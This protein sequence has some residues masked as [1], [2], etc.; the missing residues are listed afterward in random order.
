M[1]FGQSIEYNKRRCFFKNHA[2]NEAERLHL[3]NLPQQSTNIED[4][5]QGISLFFSICHGK[6]NAEAIKFLGILKKKVSKNKKYIFVYKRN[7]SLNKKVIFVFHTIFKLD[8]TMQIIYW[9][10]FTCFCCSLISVSRKR[11]IETMLTPL[12][13]YDWQKFNNMNNKRS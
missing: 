8:F 1:K 4:F 11:N 12:Y 9:I 5:C 13:S 7:V 2:Q 10:L 3:W 6:K